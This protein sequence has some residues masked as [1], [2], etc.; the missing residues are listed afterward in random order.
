M[1]RLENIQYRAAKIVTGAL[2][3]TSMEKLN[4][5]LGWESI[6]KRSDI[7]GLNIFQK[8]HLNETRP[9]IR[10][11]MPKLDFERQHRSIGGYIPYDNIGSKF[12]QSFFP[13]Y[14]GLWNSLPK[15]VQSS[16]LLDFKI[17]TKKEFKPPKYKH[18]YKGN[19]LSNS[20]LTRI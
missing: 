15:N 6:Q 19:K 11:C 20:L 10:K 14:S 3:F 18:I 8:I 13:H 12:R 5:E 9:L 16:N 7:L 1:A 2:H 4:I 17:F